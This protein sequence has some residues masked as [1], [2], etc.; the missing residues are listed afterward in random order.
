MT[1]PLGTQSVVNSPLGVIKLRDELQGCFAPAAF[2]VCK[3]YAQMGFLSAESC[4]ILA[5]R[6]SYAIELR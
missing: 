5:F 1:D 2:R 4:I 3:K 6:D